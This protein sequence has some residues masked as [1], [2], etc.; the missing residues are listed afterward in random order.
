MWPRDAANKSICN[1]GHAHHDEIINLLN[2]MHDFNCSSSLSITINLML[3][4]ISSDVIAR[5]DNDAAP[6]ARH[7]PIRRGKLASSNVHITDD[8]NNYNA[9]LQTNPEHTISTT[10][11]GGSIQSGCMFDLVGKKDITIIGIDIHITA[12]KVYESVEVWVKDDTL[13]G[14]EKSP[15][16]W[17]MVGCAQMIGNGFSN[18]TTIPSQHLE[19][20]RVAEGQ[21]K[22]S[23]RL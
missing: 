11:S 7:I 20:I 10:F 23:T 21:I 15:E 8:D 12:W 17:S 3:L 5:G 4:L 9:V 1:Y 2:K 13:I 16:F 6:V 14:Y 19:W 22:P 18:P